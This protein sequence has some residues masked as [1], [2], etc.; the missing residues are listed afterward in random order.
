[1]QQ[2]QN[3]MQYRVLQLK[4]HPRARSSMHGPCTSVGFPPAAVYVSISWDFLTHSQL[5]PA[6]SSAKTHAPA[7]PA[8]EQPQN[9]CSSVRA[10]CTSVGSSMLL[11]KTEQQK[12]FCL[13]HSVTHPGCS[14]YP[15]LTNPPKTYLCQKIFCTLIFQISMLFSP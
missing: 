8:M 10:P 9:A 11:Y 4:N 13:S 3:A 1:M 15:F 2:R 7:C 14:S 5:S 12:F 6:R